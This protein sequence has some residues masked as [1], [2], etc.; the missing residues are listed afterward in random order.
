[1]KFAQIAIAASAL[2]SAH[3]LSEAATFQ[4]VS[5]TGFTTE[6]A[7]LAN[8]YLTPLAPAGSSVA[9]YSVLSPATGFS[10]T[11]TISFAAPVTSFTFLWGSPDSY[12]RLTDGTVSVT[13]SSFS[14][15][16]GN[17]AESTLYTFIDALGFTSLTFSTTGVAFEIATA[18]VPEPQ[19]FA[20][21]LA[22][23]GAVGFMARRRG[24]TSNLRALVGRR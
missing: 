11:G 23:L 21:L 10:N 16:T 24:S 19:A 18:S 4:S 1:M 6:T 9:S 12:N 8:S 14:S 2:V 22:G 15:G 5:G 3:A 17:N 7:S 20:L 13:G